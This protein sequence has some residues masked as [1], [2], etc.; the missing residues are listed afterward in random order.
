MSMMS[1]LFCSCDD[2]ASRVGAADVSFIG[3]QN[4][5]EIVTAIKR[6]ISR[7]EQDYGMVFKRIFYQ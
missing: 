7:T 2:H 4:T 5:D 3:V 1:M 6:E